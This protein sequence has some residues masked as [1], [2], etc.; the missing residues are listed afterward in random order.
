MMLVVLPEERPCY[1][2]AQRIAQ[3]FWCMMGFFCM[4]QTPKAKVASAGHADAHCCLSQVH[5][6]ACPFLLRACCCSPSPH[7]PTSRTLQPPPLANQTWDQLKSYKPLIRRIRVCV[8]PPT[9]VVAHVH[10]LYCL[11]GGL[12]HPAG[13]PSPFTT[14][15][16][17]RGCMLRRP[18]GDH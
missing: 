7:S 10:V 2:R 4:G 8:K 17:I 1:L 13:D 9:T 16:A 3:D 18:A 6:A 14:S 15:S 11:V 12:S 5:A